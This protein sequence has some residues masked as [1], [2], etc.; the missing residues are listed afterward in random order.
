MRTRE[1]LPARR[2]SE[3]FC[4]SH[5]KFQYTATISRYEDGRLA[6]V[7]LSVAKCNTVLEGIARDA[8]ILCSLCLQ[9]GILPEAIRHSLTRLDGDVPAG[10]VC[11]LLDVLALEDAQ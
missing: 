2:E 9:H 7:F 11:R 1:Q 6:E 3:R 4:F 5:D 10:P 8:A